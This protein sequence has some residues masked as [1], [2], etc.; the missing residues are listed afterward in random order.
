MGFFSWLGKNH[1]SSFSETRLIFLLLLTSRRIRGR[2]TL[3]PNPLYYLLLQNN[4]QAKKGATAPAVLSN[5]E[6]L[7]LKKYSA[8]QKR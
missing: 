6:K 7:F 1:Y 8:R 2:A 5:P 4:F 3:I